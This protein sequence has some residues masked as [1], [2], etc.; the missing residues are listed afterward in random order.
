M[1]IL[2]IIPFKLLQFPTIF[3]TLSTMKRIPDLR[4]VYARTYRRVSFVD[5]VAS[6]R[7]VKMV[8]LDQ[9]SD[10]VDLTTKLIL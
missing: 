8:D 4:V 3:K 7:N 10:L 9:N 1:F 5:E 2:S 6:L